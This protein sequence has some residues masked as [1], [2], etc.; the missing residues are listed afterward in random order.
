M[1]SFYLTPRFKTN[2]DWF[3]L[4]KFELNITLKIQNQ[5]ETKTS[6]VSAYCHC[7]YFLIG[8][9]SIPLPVV[10]SLSHSYKLTVLL[11]FI[12]NIRIFVKCVS[13]F[14]IKIIFIVW[15]IGWTPNSVGNGDDGTTEIKIKH[16][17][18]VNFWFDSQSQL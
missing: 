14:V 5:I 13:H 8:T 1:K 3:I 17:Y 15:K 2:L 4:K 10:V 11:L 16:T 7:K 6:Y 9:Y 12:D 18:F